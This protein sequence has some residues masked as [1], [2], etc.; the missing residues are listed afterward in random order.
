MRYK[1]GTNDSYTEGK[2]RTCS[3]PQLASIIKRDVDYGKWNTYY[4]GEVNSRTAK[5]CYKKKGFS[6]H[7][8]LLIY[9]KE[10]EFKRLE[11]LIKDF[12]EVTPRKF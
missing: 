1:Y 3:V 8:H 2:G 5:C 10:E 11:N 12:I 6:F 4:G 9:G 7:S